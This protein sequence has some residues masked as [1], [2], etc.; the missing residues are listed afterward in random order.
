MDLP[1]ILRSLVRSSLDNENSLNVKAR[2]RIYEKWNHLT[3]DG[4][5]SSFVRHYEFKEPDLASSFL[6]IV[7]QAS[8]EKGLNIDVRNSANGYRIDVVV[9]GTRA[10]FDSHEECIENLLTEIEQEYTK[11]INNVEDEHS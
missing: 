2:H 9:S 6:I 11:A 10:F 5:I 4:S 3:T 1:R 8:H 7:L